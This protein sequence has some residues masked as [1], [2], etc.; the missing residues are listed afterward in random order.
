MFQPRYVFVFDHYHFPN[1]SQKSR[2]VFLSLELGSFISPARRVG[3]RQRVGTPD[4]AVNRHL[5]TSAQLIPVMTHVSR[6]GDWTGS[7]HVP[8]RKQTSKPA[9]VGHHWD[10][11]GARSE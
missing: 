1:P 11:L 3:R 8:G 5:G 7:E 6:L 2:G 10:E 4:L 9:D